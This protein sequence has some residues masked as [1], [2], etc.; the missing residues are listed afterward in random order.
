ML[1]WAFLP[2][3]D[4]RGCG[5]ENQRQR[6]DGEEEGDHI[7]GQDAR[8]ADHRQERPGQQ[9]RDHARAGFHQRHQAVGA[10][11]LLFGDHGADGRGIGRPLEGVADAVQ[12]GGDVEMPE[13]QPAQGK[14]DE[15]AAGGDDRDQVAD[16]HHQLA[17]VA[18][19]H[20]PGKGRH[21]QER[22]DEEDL[23]QPHGRGALGLLVHPDGEAKLR[24]AGGQYRDDLADPDHDK[25][26]HSN[27][28]RGGF[29][30][31]L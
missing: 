13:L 15:N 27:G 20:H 25:G 5:N 29:L 18:V 2:S 16:H 1:P 22:G 9:R 10:A 23:H 4:W 6:A 26:G 3:S 17:V 21:D 14:Q 11:Q 8:Q 30:H 31:F 28:F 19:H 12:R 24:H 7:D